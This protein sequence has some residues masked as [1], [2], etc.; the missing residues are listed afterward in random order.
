MN[1]SLIDRSIFELISIEQ[2][3]VVLLF[4]YRAHRGAKDRSSNWRVQ[5]QMSVKRYSCSPSSSCISLYRSEKNS[6]SM[7]SVFCLKS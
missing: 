6:V 1:L 3:V 5:G 4:V 2:E 7:L